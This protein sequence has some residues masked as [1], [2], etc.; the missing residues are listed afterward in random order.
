MY[1]HNPA[2]FIIFITKLYDTR[3]YV[4]LPLQIVLSSTSV[5]DKGYT[6]RF[7]WPWLGSG[8]LT[9]TGK[10]IEQQSVLFVR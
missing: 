1:S 6:Y 3:C 8:L 7:L 5:I 9:S 10:V 4:M 2:V